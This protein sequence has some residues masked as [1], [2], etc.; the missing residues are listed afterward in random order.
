MSKI[1]SLKVKVHR[2]MLPSSVCNLNKKQSQLQ[3][4]QLCSAISHALVGADELS[5][6]NIYLL[7]YY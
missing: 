5:F 2:S 1:N 7:V 3:L 4:Q 6:I